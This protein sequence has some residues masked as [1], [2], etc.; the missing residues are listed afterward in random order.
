MKIK[1]G[2]T[3]YSVVKFKSGGIAMHRIKAKPF[4]KK[5]FVKDNNMRKKILSHLSVYGDRDVFFSHKK[6]INHLK[7]LNRF[8][9]EDH[10]IVDI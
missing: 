10:Y 8:G 6:A 5:I 7:N 2:K 9:Y 4:I 3:I 1:Q